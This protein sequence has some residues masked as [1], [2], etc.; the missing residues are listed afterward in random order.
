MVSF[1]F[2]F[3]PKNISCFCVLKEGVIIIYDLL[4][5]LLFGSSHELQYFRYQENLI[6]N[7][8]SSSWCMFYIDID[9]SES[10]NTTYFIEGFIV[11]GFFT[12]FL[13]CRFLDSTELPVGEKMISYHSEELI[14][15]IFFI[16]NIGIIGTSGIIIE[17]IIEAFAEFMYM[18]YCTV[19]IFV[20]P[21]LYL[22]FSYF[23]GSYLV[24]QEDISN[25][26][27]IISSMFLFFFLRRLSVISQKSKSPEFLNY[28]RISWIAW[29]SVCSRIE[30]SDIIWHPH[31]LLGFVINS[32]KFFEIRKLCVSLSIIDKISF[33]KPIDKSSN[34]PHQFFRFLRGFYIS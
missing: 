30:E 28:M 12:Y 13:W 22:N 26:F 2:F 5:T 33:H 24:N 4:Y 16:V 18:M 29:V 6:S 10:K 11:I 8:G 25:P 21:L 1:V 20:C 19:N 15:R 9:G 32:D 3:H 14:R 23:L 31:L 17:K 7:I 27:H 34:F